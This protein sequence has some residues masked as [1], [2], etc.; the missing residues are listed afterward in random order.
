M[1]D[2]CWLSELWETGE[3]AK[4]RVELSWW[5]IADLIQAD[6]AALEAW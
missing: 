6:L 2:G 5:R 4:T 1:A 3:Q